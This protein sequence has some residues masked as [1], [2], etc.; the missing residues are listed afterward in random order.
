MGRVVKEHTVRRT[1]ILDAAQ[2]LIN[3]KGYDQMTIQDIL[4]DLQI[5]KGAFYHYFD[6]KERLLEALVDRMID[7]GAQI[8]APFV[9]DPHLSAL[10]KF[11][12]F[13]DAISRWKTARKTFLLA[14][15]KVWYS[16]H[17]TIVRQKVRVE[18]SKRFAPLLTEII[19]QGIK[20]GSM[21]TPYPDEVAEVILSLEFGLGEVLMQL[22]L[23]PEPVPDV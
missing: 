10:E 9:E 4:D 15:M 18:G 11:L 19:R 8:L 7:T 16:D 23:A 5:S 3:I 13:F 22:L 1:E 12:H 20:E 14:L 6:S 21:M 2:Q 17:N